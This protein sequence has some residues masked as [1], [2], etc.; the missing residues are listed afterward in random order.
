MSPETLSSPVLAQVTAADL[1]C[2]AGGLTLGL[3]RS[4]IDVRMGVDIDPAC[5]FPYEHNTGSRFALSDV[6]ALKADDLAEHLGG[7]DCTLIAGC[8]PCQPFS[9]TIRFFTDLREV[10]DPNDLNLDLLRDLPDL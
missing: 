4:G 9:S 3:R 8:A 6:S 1:F 10:S 7:A 2:E 5:R